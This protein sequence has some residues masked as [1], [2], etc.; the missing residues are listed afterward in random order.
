MAINPNII[1]MTIGASNSGKTYYCKNVLI[2]ELEKLGKNSYI[3]ISSDDCRRELLNDSTLD[4]YDI[5]MLPVSK[6]AFE[7]LYKKVELAMT[8]PLAKD[9][10]IVDSKGTSEKFR[11]KI[12]QL[13]RENNY[14]VVPIIFNYKN[15]EDY[16][17]NGFMTEFIR[18][19]INRVRESLS[20]LRKISEVEDIIYIK[21]P[22]F[23]KLS[24][25]EFSDR[26]RLKEKCRLE[27]DRDYLIIS[28]IHGC[29]KELLELLSKSGIEVNPETKEI[30]KNEFSKEIIFAGDYVD[31]GN[32]ILDVIEFI[33]Q[34][35]N[36][37][38]LIIGNHEYR[39]YKE[40]TGGLEH[41]DEIWYNTYD[42]IKDNEEMKNKFLDLFENYS[43]PYLQSN[44]FIVTHA[45]CQ[46]KYLGRVDNKSLARQ[47]FYHHSRDNEISLVE[48]MN[49]IHLFDNE[50]SYYY[51][52]FGH[53]P[54]IH[55]GQII[56]NRILIDG[57]CSMGKLLISLEVSKNGSIFKKEVKSS[58]PEV[59]PIYF[60]IKR[61]REEK[62]DKEI[63]LEDLTYDEIR[64]VNQM[65]ANKVNYLSGTMTPC[66]KFNNE[67]ESIESAIEYFKSRGVTDVVIQRKYM[68]S[69]C[70]MY[71]FE[72]NEESY[73]ISRNGFRIKDDLS[74]IYDKMRNRLKGFIANSDKPIK[75]II[76]DG[77]LM[78]WRALSEGLIKDFHRV[79]D[80]AEEEIRFLEESEFE[81][82]LV[83]LQDKF[84]ES[85]YSKNKSKLSK[86]ELIDLYGNTDYDTFKSFEGF[87]Y[88]FTEEK[89]TLLKTYE[90]QLR[91]YGSKGELDFKPFM[92]LKII[93]QDNSE[94]NYLTKQTSSN[95]EIFNLLNEDGCFRFDLTN[96]SHLIQLKELFLE[97]TKRDKLEGVVIKPDRVTEDRV[98]PY[99]K[100]RNPDYLTLIYGFDY[101]EESKYRGLI[102]KK[103]IRLKERVCRDEWELGKRL[104][105]I[106]YNSI[107]K[108]NKE[109][110]QLYLRF[111]KEENKEVDL[112]PRL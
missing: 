56:Q 96:E 1:F 101:R 15:F 72:S 68:G 88:I 55:A 65:I 26:V 98:I 81:E 100:V 60:T 46:N 8:F 99:M 51:H 18:Q 35:R 27:D 87:E 4:K 77:E 19:D 86:R 48:E 31:S 110:I 90:E 74:K 61:W 95:F 10:I 49:K 108:D 9:F 22:D 64:R 20:G 111:I 6:Q 66:D 13:A 79:S 83:K 33:Y 62:Q 67:L 85:N 43:Y 69:R 23:S 2:P 92:I 44:R 5:R 107:N 37:I 104:L 36:K 32:E 59:N 63:K 24:A 105:D 38:K 21:S 39:L 84:N 54:A 102:K 94:E 29:Y 112:D 78:P 106:S 25:I 34:N 70:N 12:Y 91:I 14:R 89:K 71:L 50:L 93:Y 7:L 97:L 76:I 73:C 109:L 30:I 11:E 52:I 16:K 42:Q 80:S 47:R 41:L 82:E 103:S 75:C 57:G 45:P 17:R 58:Y 3:Y 28:D 40:L 53:I